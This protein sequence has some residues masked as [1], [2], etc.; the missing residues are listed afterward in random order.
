[1]SRG[2]R[3]MDGDPGEGEAALA[4]PASRDGRSEMGQCQEKWGWGFKKASG[5]KTVFVPPLNF[6]ERFSMLTCL[7]SPTSRF[8]R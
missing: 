4:A 5:E 1:M 7:L 8:V 2:T 3:E 6:N